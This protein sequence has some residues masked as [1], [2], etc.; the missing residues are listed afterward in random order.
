MPVVNMQEAQW[1]ETR[2]AMLSNGQDTSAIRNRNRSQ[3]DAAVGYYF[4]RPQMDTTQPYNNKR[5][6]LGDDSILEQ[7][8]DM[9]ARQFVSF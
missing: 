8:G 1:Q 6:A 3:D 7:V 4:Q 9:C 2:N 5:W